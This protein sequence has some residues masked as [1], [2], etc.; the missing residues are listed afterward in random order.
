MTCNLE[1]RQDLHSKTNVLDNKMRHMTYGDVHKRANGAGLIMS[2]NRL[3]RRIN[4][5]FRDTTNDPREWRELILEEAL[6]VV[7]SLER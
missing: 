4:L 5:R 2:R 6:A 1:E 3:T 7:E